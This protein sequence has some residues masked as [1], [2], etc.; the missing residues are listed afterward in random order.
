MSSIFKTIGVAKEVESPENPGDHDNRVAVIPEDIAKLLSEGAQVFVE[1]GAGERIGFPDKDYA[2][3]GATIQDT[4]IFYQDKDLIIKLKGPSMESIPWMRRGTT[5]FCMFHLGSFPERTELLGSHGINVIAMDAVVDSP[6]KFD[7]Q[8]VSSKVA[9]RELLRPF[10]RAG[11]IHQLDVRFIGWTPKLNGAIRRA[12]NRNTNSLAVL[13]ESITTEEIDV[14]GSNAL[15]F[16]DTA[17]FSDPNGV[18]PFLKDRGCVMRDLKDFE[19]AEGPQLIKK[20][21]KDH[22]PYKFGFRKIE[23]LHGTG[24]AGARYGFKI[25]KEITKKKLAGAQAVVVVLGYGNIGMGAI[26][27]CHAQG[28]RQI[29][30]LTRAT[31]TPEKIERWLKMADLIINGA[32]LPDKD[33]GKRFLITQRHVSKV[34]TPGSVLIDLV[35]GSTHTR[36]SIENILDNTFPAD[37]YF[38]ENGIVFSALWGW[39][40]MGMELE[41]CRRYSR[42]SVELLVGPERLIDGLSALS[43]GVRR[44]LVLGPFD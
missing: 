32:I 42:Q 4:K 35:G 16:Y 2:A 23:F 21:H 38:I 37:P 5:M 12:G 27:E 34:I 8:I 15:Y 40:S 1:K 7:P 3:V 44:A 18:L 30:I 36:G 20:W 17:S 31:T 6:R 39:P 11:T 24:R 22:P 13:S 28:V 29:H 41:S 25:L 33:R 10:E 43:P 19:A 9:M 26:E 14:I